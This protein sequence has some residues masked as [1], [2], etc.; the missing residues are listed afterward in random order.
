MSLHLGIDLGGTK[1][2]LCALDGAGRERLRRRVPTPRGDYDAT[3]AAIAA[4]VHEAEAQLAARGTLGVGIPGSPSPA[5]GRI[6]NANS[7]WL[8]GRALRADLQARLAR[9]VRLANDADCFIASEAAD[10]AAAGAQVAFGVILG[11]GVG[12]GLAV[13]GR[14]LHGRNGVCGE[15]GHNPLPWARGAEH[16]GRRCW[17]GQ[18]GCIETWLS[19]PGFA[20]DHAGEAPTG[21]PLVDAAE[22]V[23]RM[24]AGD[25]QAGAAF[26]RYVDRLGR[27]LAHVINL[28]DPD[29]IVLGGG[30]SNVDELYA[31]VPLAWGE[32]VFSDVVATPLVRAVH[33]DSSGVRGAAW[34]WLAEN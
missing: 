9:E 4:L 29:V 21:V 33:G 8:N 12:G 6:R 19:G 30:M 27:A 34:L 5:D 3:L 20:A 22:I 24:R 1:I 31:Q 25:A 2:E 7:T 11:T 32:H 17:C 13:G 18:R 28:V 16:P 14:A 23:A 10:G 26:A 15:W